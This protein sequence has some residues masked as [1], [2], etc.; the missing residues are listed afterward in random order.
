MGGVIP[1]FC[2]NF[3][4]SDDY[5]TSSSP[6]TRWVTIYLSTNFKQ[7]K[8]L[9][10]CGLALAATVGAWADGYN[11][12][13]VS[14]DNVH[15]GFNTE[16]KVLSEG[17]ESAS[18][19]GFGI[20]YTHG[21]G[22]GEKPMFIETGLSFVAAFG[23]TNDVVDVDYY[24]DDFSTW[25]EKLQNMFLSVPVNYVYRFNVGEKFTIA[26][27]AGINFKLNLIGK[28]KEHYED[29]DGVEESEWINVYSSDE[30]NMGDKDLTWNRFQM[31]WQVGVG[32]EYSKVYLGVQYGTDFIPA[33]S[34]KFSE[35]G[36][37]LTPKVN[38]GALKVSVGYTF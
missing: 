33:Y 4:A 11:R 21:F 29:E 15:F 22:L 27:Y 7:M 32:F 3:A 34:H 10:A 1:N 5:R 38:T 17:I 31:G 23:K 13:S 2:Y 12:V 28:M 14:Y 6:G 8:R 18:A 20:N 16:M 35:G 30:K 37:S 19:N 25:H 26:P 36:I 24:Y 9:L